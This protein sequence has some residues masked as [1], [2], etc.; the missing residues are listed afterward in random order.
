MRSAVSAK[1][2]HPSS[3]RMANRFG[4]IGCPSP[5][6]V[7][8][9]G[10]SPKSSAMVPCRPR[11]PAEPVITTLSPIDH[12]GVGSSVLA[13]SVVIGS[14]NQVHRLFCALIWTHALSLEGHTG[15]AGPV[16]RYPFM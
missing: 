16:E 1:A 3:S 11:C 4:R 14:L 7:D 6:S 12:G 9:S 15:F 2:S 8:T 10:N 13:V 5:R